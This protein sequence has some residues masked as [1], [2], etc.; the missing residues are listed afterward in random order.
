[1]ENVQILE[2]TDGGVGGLIIR[3]KKNVDKDDDAKF[4]APKLPHLEN[5]S[6]LGLDILAAKK[7]KEREEASKIK[8][9]TKVKERSYRRKHEETPS[10]TGGVADEAKNVVMKGR[11]RNE[12]EDFTYLPKTMVNICF[13]YIKRGSLKGRS[14]HPS[15]HK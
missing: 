2:G 1:M 7:E 6:L 14:T 5:R 8:E 9:P 12:I 15:F 3:K 13:N 11:T 4:V 10:H